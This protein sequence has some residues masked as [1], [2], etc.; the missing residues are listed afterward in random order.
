M[1]PGDQDHQKKVKPEQ[2]RDFFRSMNDFLHE[3]PIKGFLQSIDE[4]FSSPFPGGGFHV[5]KRE[6]ENEYIITAELPGIKKE[7]INISVRYNTIT[8]SVE[9]NEIETKE[10]L[11]HH[12]F[13]KKIARQR[14]SRTLSL[15]QQINEKMIK[16]SYRDGLLQIIIPQEKGRMIRIEE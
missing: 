3:K 14:T 15:P 4:F 8:I 16:A 11:N 6:T 9:N 10:D 1:L 5:E 7:Q 12:T 13:Q 2:F